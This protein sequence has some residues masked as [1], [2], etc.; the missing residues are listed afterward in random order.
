VEDAARA[1]RDEARLWP[2]LQPVLLRIVTCAARAVAQRRDGFRECIANNPPLLWKSLWAS[3][4][5]ERQGRV[6][7]C[8]A[9]D[10]PRF[11]Q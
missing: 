7:A 11:E 9:L 2:S 5:R 4:G 3:G 8:F 1:G 6:I 10:C